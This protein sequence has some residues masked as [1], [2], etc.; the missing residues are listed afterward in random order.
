MSTVKQTLKSIPGLVPLV[1]WMRGAPLVLPR[2]RILQ[3]MPPQSVGAEIGVHE[4]DF[5]ERILNEVSP[6]RL[7]LIDPWKHFGKPEY[8]RSWYGGSDVEQREMDRRF[9]RA[10]RRFRSQTETG[11]VQL[12]RSTS[13]E[14]VD[15]FENAYFDWVYIDGNHLYEYVR[16][17]LENY[18]PRVKPGGYSWATTTGMKGGGIT[19]CKRPSTSL[20]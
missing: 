13:E 12:Y 18:H 19:G 3:K 14:A 4:G 8:D 5:S 20:L 16:D 7:H 2:E 1:R 11:T 6:R 15:L 10:K 17:D 9:E